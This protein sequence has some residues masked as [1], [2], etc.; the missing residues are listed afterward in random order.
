MINN[1]KVLTLCGSVRF[2]D[3]MR[4]LDGTLTRKGYVILSVGVVEHHDD[5][6]VALH[7]ILEEVHF[8]KIDLSDAILVVNCDPTR[9][10]QQPP[11]TGIHTNMEIAYAKVTNKDIFFLHSWL[12]HHG[13]FAL[14]NFINRFRPVV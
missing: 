6:E 11:Y 9:L 5:N 8:A 10:P 4:D 7:K 14:G 3:M 13:R 1:R 2:M 12:D